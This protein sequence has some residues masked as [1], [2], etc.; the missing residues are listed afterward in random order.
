MELNMGVRWQK[1]LYTRYG[2]WAVVTGASSG[3]G[4]EMAFKLAEA[5][6]NLVLSARSQEILEQMATD[7]MTRYGIEVRV[8]GLDLALEKGA[9]TLETATQDLDV[10]LLIASAGFGSRSGSC[11]S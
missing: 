9:E 5:R 7:L 6:L 1:R 3:I 4:R 11:G 2:P 10:G 8:V